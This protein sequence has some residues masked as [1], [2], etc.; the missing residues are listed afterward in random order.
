MAAY[1]C[2]LQYIMAVR[3]PFFQRLPQ[4]R[5]PYHVTIDSG[6]AAFVSGRT[7]RQPFLLF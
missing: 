6:N 3:K 5:Q 4:P 2:Y 7:G 1:G